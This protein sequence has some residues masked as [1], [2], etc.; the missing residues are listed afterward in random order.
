[1]IAVLDDLRRI[2]VAVLKPFG[3]PELPEEVR[4]SYHFSDDAPGRARPRGA[5]RGVD[6]EVV[7]ISQR[8]D[9][10]LHCVAA[11][12]FPKATGVDFRLRRV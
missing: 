2:Q 12:R 4:L 8:M 11:L 3:V 6:D 9:Y 1:M 7:I 5:I 10:C